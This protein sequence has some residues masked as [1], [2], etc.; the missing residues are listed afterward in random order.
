[1]PPL[2]RSELGG[3]PLRG[4]SKLRALQAQHASPLLD[5]SPS[6]VNAFIVLKGTPGFKATKIE[7]KIA[8]RCVQV[9]GGRGGAGCLAGSAAA[10]ARMWAWALS[11]AVA[12]YGGRKTLS[13]ARTAALQA[14]AGWKRLPA[15]ALAC[16]GMHQ[17]SICCA[18]A[19]AQL[20]VAEAAR[21]AVPASQ[22]HP[23]LPVLPLCCRTRTC[24]LSAASSRIQ[25]ACQGLTRSRT[26]TR[27]WPSA[28][29]CGRVGLAACLW[30][31]LRQATQVDHSEADDRS[32]FGCSPLALQLVVRARQLSCTQVG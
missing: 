1:M 5:G 29:V 18:L 20:W 28:G 11:S 23:P 13:N 24:C 16:S 4:P 9:S 3:I 26:Q 25:R 12:S 15:L 22:S 14:V 27:C 10:L 8:L 31:G 17:G 19:R 7:N 2:Q 32:A 6:Q 21:P 30:P